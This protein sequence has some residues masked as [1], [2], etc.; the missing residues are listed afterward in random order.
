MFEK[1][2]SERLNRNRLDRR[3]NFVTLWKERYGG[4]PVKVV[5][6]DVRGTVGSP[7]RFVTCC[8]DEFP[9][10]HRDGEQE[11]ATDLWRRPHPLLSH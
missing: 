4:Q 6:W 5:P 2:G 9:A 8:S 11:H 1:M 10:D 3:I 7:R